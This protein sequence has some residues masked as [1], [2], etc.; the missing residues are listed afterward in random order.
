MT[1]ATQIFK[2]VILDGS[3]MGSELWTIC[4]DYEQSLYVFNFIFYTWFLYSLFRWSC[5]LQ[6]FILLGFQWKFGYNDIFMVFMYVIQSPNLA[7]P[8]SPHCLL[9][10][11]KWN[12]LLKQICLK[13]KWKRW[14][15]VDYKTH[16][17]LDTIQHICK[18]TICY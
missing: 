12:L 2:K 6:L 3:C 10:K 14:W 17:L 16:A 18:D 1:I 7:S 11:Q 5:N 9:A 13:T 8:S 15:Q 4:Y